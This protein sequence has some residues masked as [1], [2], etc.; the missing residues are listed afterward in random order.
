MQRVVWWTLSWR[1]RSSPRALCQVDWD[2]GMQA[3]IGCF[4]LGFC[5]LAIRCRACAAQ[6]SPP[7]G[8]STMASEAGGSPCP[9]Q[10][11]MLGDLRRR[12]VAGMG[13]SRGEVV[14]CMRVHRPL[15]AQAG[16][17]EVRIELTAGF[18]EKSGGE[19]V[20]SGLSFRKG[21]LQMMHASYWQIVARC[22]I[23]RCLNTLHLSNEL[24]DPTCGIGKYHIVGR[25]TK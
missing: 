17:G 20:P 6:S 22:G 13:S 8:G 3:A 1:A 4:H 12:D 14:R 15:A 23:L 5:P 10:L 16:K 2:G 18:A 9:F 7:V 25:R 24:D 21:L 19:L 11:E